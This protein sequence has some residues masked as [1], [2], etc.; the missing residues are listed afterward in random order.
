[1]RRKVPTCE[2]FNRQHKVIEIESIKSRL[3]IYHFQ[4]C[5]V[6]FCIMHFDIFFID[7]SEERA[8]IISIYGIAMQLRQMII[9]NVRLGPLI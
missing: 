4:S 1:M 3:P 5:C 7:S 9:N 2:T 6:F 8:R